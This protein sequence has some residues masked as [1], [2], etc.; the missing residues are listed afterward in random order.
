MKFLI[1]Y[2]RRDWEKYKDLRNSKR[3]EVIVFDGRELEIECK[4]GDKNDFFSFCLLDE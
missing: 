4:G 3:V 1:K 2:D